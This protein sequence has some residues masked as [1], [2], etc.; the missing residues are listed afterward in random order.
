MQPASVRKPLQTFFEPLIVE[1]PKNIP[2]E[3]KCSQLQGLLALATSRVVT[4]LS[5]LDCSK[6]KLALLKLQE[7]AS[8]R[9]IM[10]EYE[11]M[12]TS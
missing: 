7:H 10:I 9:R 12:A 1:K 4:R 11:S 6:K 2:L 5:Y 3:V 8:R